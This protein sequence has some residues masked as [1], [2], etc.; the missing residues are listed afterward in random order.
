MDASAPTDDRR[1]PR[2]IALAAVL[3]LVL[4]GVAFTRLLSVSER[5][6]PTSAAA[7]SEA[8]SGERVALT[9]R[10]P[11]EADDRV[12]VPWRPGLTVVEATRLAGGVG[13]QP[14]RSAWR[15]AGDLAFLT[16][17]GGVANGG[18]AG[19][20]WLFSVNG[21]RSELGAGAVTLAE[22]DRVLWE[23]AE[24]E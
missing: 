18:A 23:L 9:R 20:N 24:Y 5:P 2:P 14:W 21:E 4:I 12:E 8:P 11:G 16:E 6:E 3:A 13:G 17:L 19:R 22:D 15:G 10:L 7:A 1:A